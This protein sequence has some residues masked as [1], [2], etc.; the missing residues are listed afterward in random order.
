MFSHKHKHAP[1]TLFRARKVIILEGLTSVYHKPTFS[2]IFINF[3]SF[4]PGMYN[5]GLIETLLHRSFRL[6]SNYKNFHQEIE[7]ESQYSNTIIILKDL[8]INVLKSVSM[9][10]L[11]KQTLISWFLCSKCKVA[12][13]WKTFYHFYSKVAEH[14]RISNLTENTWKM[15]SSLQ[16]LII[17]YNAIAL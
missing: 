16:Y 13:Y 5:C 9:N 14:M 8:G 3:E 11:S 10:Y 15:L 4:V 1:K 17:Y 12:N 7:T 2:G 6:R